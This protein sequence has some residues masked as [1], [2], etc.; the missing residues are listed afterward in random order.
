M[1]VDDY[2]QNYYKNEWARIKLSDKPGK[3]G[4]R[5]MV[6]APDFV[7]FVSY[8][9]DNH[10]KGTVLDLGCGGG[11]HSI[12]L[13]QNGFEVNGI[14]FADIAIK[15][16]RV[17]A[18]EAGVDKLTHFEVG[19]VLN[20][21][22]A[23]NYFDVI[24]DDGCLHHIDPA[25]WSTYLNNVTR[26]LKRGGIL[27]VKAFSKNCKYFKENTNADAS[28]W[29]RL[30]DSGYTYFFDETDIRQLF[31]G[32]FKIINLIENAHTVTEAKKFFFVVL[33]LL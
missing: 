26:V 1:N 16:A 14:D 3:S 2:Q 23:D 32:K 13:A 28:Q 9:K 17:N 8:L 7:N 31:S 5:T 4:W 12:L 11:R 19:N 30:D 6:P 24:N 10:I 29:V 15:Q 25:E 22:Y 18:H 20:L 33:K 27:R 21:P